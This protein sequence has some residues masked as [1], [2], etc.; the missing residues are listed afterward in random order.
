MIWRMTGASAGVFGRCPRGSKTGAVQRT[1]RGS[2]REPWRLAC[3]LGDRLSWT[4]ARRRPIG[5]V[6][7][8]PP[9]PHRRT[10]RFSD[11]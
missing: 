7:L 6:V 2:F 10:I 3:I 1:R 9:R 4:A 11:R 8:Q 5:E